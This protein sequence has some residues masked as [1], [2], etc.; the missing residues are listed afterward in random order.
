MILTINDPFSIV[1]IAVALVL[2]GMLK[3]AL[4]MGSPIIAVPVMASIIDVQ[5]AVALM[6]L[7]NL[8]TNVWQLWSY[9]RGRMAGR[10]PWL[11][12]LGG[13]IGVALGTVMLVQFA[14]ETLKLIVAAS[15]LLYVGLRLSRPDLTISQAM[16]VRLAA[17]LGTLAGLLQGAAG[18]SAPISVSFL[19]AMKLSREVFIPTISLFFAVMTAVQIPLLAAVGVMTP[20]VVLLGAAALAPLFLGM[21][22][23]AWAARSISPKAFDRVILVVLVLLAL[24]L[25]YDALV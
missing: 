17:P 3:G 20:E 11:F 12:A 15:V 23:G 9:R 4:G 22:I 25:F 24:K 2:G 21:P 10:F 8:S 16:S 13:G 19:N 1:A 5:F 7:P 14:P 18:I 6:V